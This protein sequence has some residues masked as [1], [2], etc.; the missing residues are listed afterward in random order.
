MSEPRLYIADLAAYNAGHLHGIW[1]DACDDL[2][3]IKEAIKTML[4]NSPVSDAEEV[5]I[6]DYEG[7]E[8]YEIGEYE[9]IKSAHET[10]CFIEQH[11]KLGARLLNDYCQDAQDAQHYIKDKYQGCYGS[12]ADYA[13]EQTEGQFKIPKPLEF[14]ID[15][16]RMAS[17]WEMSGDIFTIETTSDE[18][19]IFNNH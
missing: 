17:D 16:E 13:Q 5:A 2:D 8:G 7:F 15:Y 14:Y 3:D 18:V 1:I 9:G 19:H 11:G 6:H 4:D 10:A 12:T